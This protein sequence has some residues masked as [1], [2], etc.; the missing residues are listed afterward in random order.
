MPSSPRCPPPKP[1]AANA[2]SAVPNLLASLP[3]SDKIDYAFGAFQRGFYLTAFEIAVERAKLG[4]AKAQSLIGYLYANGLGL[5]KSLDEAIIWYQLAA[6]NGD[7]Q[8]LVELA[9]LA[10]LGIGMPV[11]K[12][13]A[14]TYLEEALGKGVVEANYWL[15]LLCIDPSSGILDYA[16]PPPCS[17][18]AA[19]EGNIDAIYALAALFRREGQGVVKNETEAARLMGEAAR[20]GHLAAQVEYA[21]MMFNIF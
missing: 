16:L 17:R 15:G 4:D 13:K 12:K 20:A 14:A 1:P 9:N 10:A 2:A 6:R 5:P 8:A 3:D 21:I 18:R 11:D 19:D 7:P